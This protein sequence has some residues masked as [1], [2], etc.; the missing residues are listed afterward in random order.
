MYAHPNA[1]T[2]PKPISI[3]I[4]T[5][6]ARAYRGEANLIDAVRAVPLR[7]MREINSTEPRVPNPV[8]PEEDFADKWKSEPELETHFYQWLVQVQD[9]KSTRLNSSHVAISY[10]VFC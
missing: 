8:N 2:D 10:A 9:R 5:L 7:M 4:T 1:N 6:A 3:I